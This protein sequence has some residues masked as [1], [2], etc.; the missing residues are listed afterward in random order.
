VDDVFQGLLRKL[1]V[2]ESLDVLQDVEFT[3]EGGIYLM[4]DPSLPRREVDDIVQVLRE[5]NDRLALA[6][7]PDGTIGAAADWWV[8][9]LPGQT[10][11]TGVGAQASAPQQ[12]PSPG[13]M[14]GANEPP[15]QQMVV[16]A[17]TAIGSIAGGL[18]LDAALKGM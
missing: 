16:Q 3:D 2:I 5:G 13:E 10:E 6:G 1:V 18:D 8:V 14:P 17:K 12:A 11:G 7:A 9:F 4:F 15:R